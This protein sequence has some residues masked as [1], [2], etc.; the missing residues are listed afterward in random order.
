[1]DEELRLAVAGLPGLEEILGELR[2][3]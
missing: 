1:M 3:T 2:E